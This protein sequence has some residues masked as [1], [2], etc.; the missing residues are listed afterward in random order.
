MATVSR[1]TA[2]DTPEQAGRRRDLFDVPTWLTRASAWSWRLLLLVAALVVLGLLFVRLRVVLV[3]LLAATMLASVLSPAVRRLHERGLPLLLATWVVLLAVLALVGGMLAGAVWGLSTELAGDETQWS[4]VGDD[5]RD[6]LRTGPLGLDESTVD[7]LEQR[8]RQAI[9]GGFASFG[10]TRARMLV[11][12]VSGLFLTAA[13]TFFFV[14]DGPEMWD[15]MT[16]R[17]DPRRRAAVDEAGREAAAT[18]SAYLRAVALTGFIDAIVIG[19]GLLIIGVPLVV[20]LTIITFFGAFLPVVGATAA[21]GIAALVALVAGGPGDAVLVIVLTL[22]V[23]QI[24]GD[25][26]MPMIMGRQVSLHPAAV[27]AALTAGGAL[28]GVIGAFVAV[29]LAA[30]AATAIGVLR[31]HRAHERAGLTAAVAGG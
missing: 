19:V 31:R 14:K 1:H 29:P 3:P 27:L 17:V 5:V 30:V 18:L 16:E 4:E 8:T 28:A 25:V 22:V 9:T 6:W 15:W 10:T 7:E 12:L 13:L 23:Q 26:L 11:E 2:T 24:E 20:P 21:G